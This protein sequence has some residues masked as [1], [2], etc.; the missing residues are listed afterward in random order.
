MRLS[1]ETDAPCFIR[2][3][4]RAEEHFWEHWATDAEY[5]RR[6]GSCMHRRHRDASMAEQGETLFVAWLVIVLEWLVYARMTGQ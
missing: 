1:A 5:R 3:L 4:R 6:F 2:L